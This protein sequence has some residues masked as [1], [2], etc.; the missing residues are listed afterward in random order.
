MPPRYTVRDLVQLIEADGW[1]KVRV[2]G[3]HAQYRHPT[4]RGLVTIPGRPGD[5]VAPGTYNSVLK[6]AGMK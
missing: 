3:S 6:Q 5:P 2:R 4:K 1:Y